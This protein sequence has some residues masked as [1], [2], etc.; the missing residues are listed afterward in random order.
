MVLARAIQRAFFVNEVHG[1]S[2]NLYKPERLESAEWNAIIVSVQKKL[3]ADSAVTDLNKTWSAWKKTL[4]QYLLSQ[5]LKEFFPLAY[6]YPMLSVV[7]S[8]LALMHQDRQI[9]I[10]KPGEK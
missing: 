7:L 8:F 3:I 10:D 9:G 2:N 4:Y 1:N 6:S 5:I